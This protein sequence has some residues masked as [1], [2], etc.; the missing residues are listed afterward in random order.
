M[1]LEIEPLQDPNYK[2]MQLKP[3][4]HHEEFPKNNNLIMLRVRNN[5]SL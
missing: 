1:K 3:Q 2:G 5:L 4:T